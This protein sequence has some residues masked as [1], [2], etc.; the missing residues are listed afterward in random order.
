MTT[1]CLFLS[2][3]SHKVDYFYGLSMDLLGPT[4]S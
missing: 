4:P 3:E 2:D 1:C